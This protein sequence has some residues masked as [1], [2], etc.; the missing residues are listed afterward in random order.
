MDKSE[1]LYNKKIDQVIWKTII[2]NVTPISIL[3]RLEDHS[4]CFL[5]ESVGG[6][7]KRQIFN[8]WDEA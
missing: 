7:K 2:S 8:R 3:M 4:N 5:L 1:K 6:Y